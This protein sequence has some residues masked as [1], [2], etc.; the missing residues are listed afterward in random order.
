MNR[1]I[2]LLGLIALMVMPSTTYA[3][4]IVVLSKEADLP[5]D[6][7]PEKRSHSPELNS[8]SHTLYANSLSNYANSN[9]RHDNS[10]SN[11][12]N[13]NDG[14]SRLLI[15]QD[16]QYFYIGYYVINEDMLINFYAPNGKRLFYGPP[17]TSA[18]FHSNGG[19]FCGTFATVNKKPVLA[20]TEIGQSILLANQIPVFEHDVQPVTL[21]VVKGLG[22]FEGAVIVA[23]NGQYLGKVTLD[24]LNSD[25]ITN[26]LGA[27][28]S[29]ISSLSIFNTI[30]RYG[31]TASSLSPWNSS[32]RT[33]PI[34]K[35]EDE[36]W[37][38]LSTNARLSPRMIPLAQ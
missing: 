2:I 29:K 28:G 36:Q 24:D 10:P 22:D 3:D 30:G 38:Y 8:N 4:F 13:S 37:A 25:S 21:S 19:E 33:P 1:H 14:N 27:Y 6:I 12:K 20:I 35:T 34:I 17:D 5:Y 23:D 31:N 32:T 26:H 7:S 18:I 9:S 16:K 15:E 11:Y